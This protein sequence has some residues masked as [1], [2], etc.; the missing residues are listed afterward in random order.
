MV[1]ICEDCGN[2][3]GKKRL[4]ISSWHQGE[5]NY[6]G[7]FKSVTQDRDFGYPPL[8]GKSKGGS[9]N[10]GKKHKGPPVQRTK[11]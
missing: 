3:Y 1:W 10:N 2:R 4:G 11:D 7:E 9:C 5:C 8:P 6:C